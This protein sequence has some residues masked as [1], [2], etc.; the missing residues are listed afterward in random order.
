MSDVFHS[1]LI[2]LGS[3]PAGCTAAI[4]AARAGVQTTLLQGMQP[5]GQLTITTEVENYPGFSDIIQGP[6][7]MTEMQKQAE[8]CGTEMKFDHIKEVNFSEDGSEAHKLIGESGQE[9]SCY[10]L[11]ICTGASAKWLGIES[12]EKFMSK[13]VSGCATCDGAFYRNQDVLV[14]GG[15]NTAL[16]EALYLANG[17][18][19]VTMIHR[20][21]EFRGEVVL[22][23]RVKNHEKI[24]I[25]W[26]TELDEILGDD[27]GVTGARLLDNK[28]GEKSDHKFMGVFIAIGHKPNT[29]LFTGKLDMDETGYLT[30]PAGSVTTKVPGV[31]AAGDVMDHTYR[32]AVT[33]AG[34]GCMAALD[35]AR[36]LDE[37]K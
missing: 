1:D 26:N 9:Y 21:D 29:G 30:V 11:I 4:Y 13:G 15:G 28:T 31:Y 8:N 25:I 17:C 2:I 12:E 19:S 20:R 18:K 36:Y 16:E 22:R 35:S 14:V 27:M 10:S 23:E 5:G 32:Q 6:W 37:R 34:F 3:G 33:S 7:L 24:N